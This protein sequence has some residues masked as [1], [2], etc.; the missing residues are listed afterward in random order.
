MKAYSNKNLIVPRSIVLNDALDKVLSDIDH[1][2]D[3]RSEKVT[4]GIRTSDDQIRIIRTYLKAK[5][6]DKKYLDAMNCNV[7]D[8]YSDSNQFVWQMGWSAL[9][10]VGV[11]I[12]PPYTAEVLMDYHRNGVNKKGQIISPSP[13][14]RGTAFDISGLDSLDIVKKLLADGKI[15]GYLVERENSCIHIDILT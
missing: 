13:H 9:L 4:S 5:G 1:Y 2:W 12:N 3:G 14:T 11:I 10:N 6:L 8:K 15:K 7:R